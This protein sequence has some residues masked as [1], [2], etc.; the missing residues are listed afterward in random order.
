MVRK[1]IFAERF[2]VCWCCCDHLVRAMAWHGRLRAIPF[3][4][5]LNPPRILSKQGAQSPASQLTTCTS[6]QQARASANDTSPRRRVT[7]PVVLML[8]LD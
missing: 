8:R 1:R 6:D 3:D 2:N 4:P 5:S 7:W